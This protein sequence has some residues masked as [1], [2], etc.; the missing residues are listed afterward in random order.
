MGDRQ[1]STDHLLISAVDED[2]RLL[3]AQQFC[4]SFT[5]PD[6][7]R[8]RVLFGQNV[9]ARSLI[10]RYPIH[11]VVDD[12]STSQHLDGVPI[13]RSADIPLDALVLVLSGGRPLTVK[14]QLSTR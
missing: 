5:S 8:P 9:Y 1:V 13:L 7:R 3:H 4:R 14:D 6:S 12:F 11:G 10:Q 2:T